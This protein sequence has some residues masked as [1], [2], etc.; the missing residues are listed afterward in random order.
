MGERSHIKTQTCLGTDNIYD[1]LESRIQ[2]YFQIDFF[3][4]SI[5]FGILVQ[6]SIYQ[7]K[8]CQKFGKNRIESCKNDFHNVYNTILFLAIN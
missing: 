1:S 8:K 4:V 6:F 7:K 5:Y 3:L 2:Y